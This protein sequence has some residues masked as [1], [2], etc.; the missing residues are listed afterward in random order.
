MWHEWYFFKTSKGVYSSMTFDS[1]P[2]PPL[3][4][5]FDYLPHKIIPNW[6]IS[7]VYSHGIMIT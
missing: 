2:P 5:G 1:L 3:L 4:F 7:I 6:S